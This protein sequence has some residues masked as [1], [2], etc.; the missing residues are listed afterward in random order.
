LSLSA[1]GNA[2]FRR[3]TPGQRPGGPKAI[4]YQSEGPK[5]FLTSAALCSER[6]IDVCIIEYLRDSHFL[7]DILVM[8][9]DT[10]DLSHER[11]RSLSAF[12]HRELDLHTIEE[13]EY[14]IIA[15]S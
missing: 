8:I 12:C 14:A 1:D 11:E 3:P 5:R 10:H 4:S 13:Q 6:R 15:R 2:R 9:L 7:N